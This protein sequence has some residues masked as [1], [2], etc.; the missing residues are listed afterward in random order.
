MAEQTTE[1]TTG[2]AAEEFASAATQLEDVNG[3]TPQPQQA[4]D[5]ELRKW[6]EL[7]RK[8]ESAAHKAQS[9]LAAA[10]ARI[11]A[12]EDAAQRERDVSE[13]AA[14]TGV[15]AS[16]IRGAN[17]AE[18]EEHAKAIAEAY[19]RP[20]APQVPQAGS[21]SANARPFAELSEA[22]KVR[23]IADGISRQLGLTN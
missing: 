3:A 19:A 13:V 9:E 16:L 2:Q 20:T 17:R 15:P 8:N 21:F 22:D 7:S 23:A 11:K 4:D 14:A 5:A 1:P 12:L 10:N 18:M 6:K